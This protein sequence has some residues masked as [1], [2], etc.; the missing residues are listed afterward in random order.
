MYVNK[1][2]FFVSI[3]RHIKF[4][5]AEMLKSESAAQLMASFKLV[6]QTYVTRGFR[7]TSMMVDGKFEPLQGELAGLGID[8]NCVSRDAHV[9][10]IERHI[11]TV[12]ERTRCIYN[13]LPFTAIRFHESHRLHHPIT[14]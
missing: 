3:S 12:K 9:P 7:V 10:E 1:I 2:P 6:T 4:G 8:V 5:T 14:K 13:Q 11:R